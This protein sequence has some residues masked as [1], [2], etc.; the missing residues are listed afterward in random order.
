M[1]FL[2]KTH[3]GLD[4][5][6]NSIEVVEISISKGK[7][8]ISKASRVELSEGIVQGG[9]IL[10]Q[11]LLKRS[12]KRAFGLTQKNKIETKGIIFGIP[13]SLVFNHLYSHLII[14]SE[15]TI[16][17]VIQKEA[18]QSIPLGKADMVFSYKNFERQQAEISGV[19]SAISRKDL[20]EWQNFFET[21]DFEV[22]IFEPKTNALLRS[23]GQKDKKYPLC[24][25][26]I[27][28]L[29][30]HINVFDN[31]GMVF[32]NS[33]KVGGEH[34]A[35]GIARDLSMSDMQKVREMTFDEGLLNPGSQLCNCIVNVIDDVVREIK[36]SVEYIE[37]KTGETVEMVLLSGGTAL[38]PGIV[39]YF[40]ANIDKE[41]KPAK[42][43]VSGM[44]SNEKKIMFL[45]AAG[46]AL[47][48]TNDKWKDDVFFKEKIS[49]KKTAAPEKNTS[50]QS[51]QAGGEVVQK[52]APKKSP[53]KNILGYEKEILLLLLTIA[54]VALLVFAF[55]GRNNQ[56]A[57][58]AYIP[59]EVQA[60]IENLPDTKEVPVQVVQENVS[61]TTPN[62]GENKEIKQEV[63]ILETPTGWLNVRSGPGTEHEIVGK[64]YP[65]E[66]YEYLD[67][68]D[69][70]YIIHLSD[71]TDGWVISNY[72]E[73]VP[74][75]IN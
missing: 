58:E 64:V 68:E 12:L 17:E 8:K 44:R 56:T 52:T 48:T 63:E 70:W 47:R 45:K 49:R 62:L 61:T 10:N 57:R 75:E 34:I 19:I 50:Q 40:S 4:I 25:I 69:D 55:T 20:Q 41:I 23:V 9:R 71:E 66:R 14:G 36:A 37:N 33:L 13:E 28:S 26:D 7:T 39:D 11:E 54:L 6:D 21:S 65:Q 74:E 24:V 35:Q 43:S 38:I 46:L 29:S 18:H 2:S 16:D 15:S 73:E 59:P 31:L 67:I 1:N 32:N 5:S 72:V 42:L 30:T 53:T 60:L 27:G 51:S 3:V 22:E